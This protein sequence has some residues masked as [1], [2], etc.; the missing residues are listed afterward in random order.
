MNVMATAQAPFSLQRL[1]KWARLSIKGIGGAFVLITALSIFTSLLT[2]YN[3][4]LI[5][6]FIRQASS[7]SAE[8]VGTFDFVGFILP[9]DAASTAILFA[10]TA[11][12]LIVT[13]FANRVGTAWFNTMMLQR[14]QLKLHDKL[15][16]LGYSY[17]GNHDVGENTAVVMQYAAGAQGVLRDVLAFPFT[18]GV[19]LLSAITFLFYNISD[20]GSPDVIYALLA[21]LLL[22]LPA[23]GVWL[24]SR[25]RLAYSSVR[26]RQGA[27]GNVLIDSLTAP[28]EVQL[29][30]AGNQRSAAFAA[31]LKALGQ[32]QVQAQVQNELSSQFQAAVPTVLQI[33]LILWAVFVVGGDAVQAVVG[34]YLFVPRVVEPIQAL[35]SF[36]AGLNTAWPN[37]ERVG[38]V[39]DEPAD[40][41][42]LGVKTASELG[43]FEV[44]LDR[45]SFRPDGSDRTILDDLRKT[46]VPGKVTALVGRS[47]SGKTTIMR[48]IVR[49]F[50]PTGGSVTI[51]GTDVREI[52]LEALRRISATV[53]QFPLF[54]EANVRENLRLGAA[55]ANDAQMEAACRA[56]DV[57]NALVTIS[58]DDPLGTPVPRQAG[59]AG[60]AGGER[61]RLAI[62]RTL[63]SD[64]QILL[65]DEPST[66]I[67]AMSVTRILAEFRSRPGRTI[68][69][70]DH[71]MDLIKAVADEVCCIEGGKFTDVGT[72]DGLLQRPSLFKS[73]WE[74]RRTYGNATD[75]EVQ[76]SVPVRPAFADI[77]PPTPG[78]QPPRED[79]KTPRAG[80]GPA[81]Y[82]QQ[83]GKNGR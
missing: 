53:S 46:F 57:W 26:D 2:L 44:T 5:A 39:L 68:L 16:Q 55:D 65:L 21:V 51:G 83:G 77:Q 61:R 3:A 10:A 11:I 29:M 20:L 78:Q 30:N 70:I 31:R 79:R 50:D 74:A 40:V 34:I 13:G 47:G 32:A 73:L 1:L 36:Y 28:Q 6:N 72:P 56:A 27:L 15:L 37:I 42:D 54:I 49:L 71:D 59:K 52:K 12:L 7:G 24:S 19:S 76:G 41:P 64:A 23:G 35:V 75:F 62:A 48:L 25:L 4:Q 66:G 81:E 60:L 18:R 38:Q 14:M 58:P 63:L 69:I 9:R 45:L 43:S 33:G 17:H 22:V 67:D 82:A 80:G 8:T